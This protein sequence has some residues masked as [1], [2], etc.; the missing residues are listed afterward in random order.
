MFF[1][2]EDDKLLD[3][4]LDPGFSWATAKLQAA[5][6][7]AMNLPLALTTRSYT[8]KGVVDVD[9]IWQYFDQTIPMRWRAG[10]M[11][12]AQDRTSMT[13]K[14]VIGWQVLRAKLSSEERIA[15]DYLSGVRR[16]DWMTLRALERGFAVDPESGFIR[17]VRPD[18]GGP[19]DSRFLKKAFPLM[20]RLTE[21]DVSRV[22]SMHDDEDEKAV[23]EAMLAAPA[24][25]VVRVP[26]HLE[27]EYLRILQERK[28]WKIEVEARE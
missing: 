12:V 17:D 23:I 4:V 21:L 7:G 26:D 19:I 20:A 8:T 6:F 2:G 3:V 11:G 10:F 1:V 25:K 9:F 13:L 15:A 18:F 16:L 14:P 22:L 27:P 28:D 24:V 5:S